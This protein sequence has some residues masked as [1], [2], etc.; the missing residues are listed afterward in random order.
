M[1]S[2]TI[3][4]LKYISK[5]EQLAENYKKEEYLIN[6]I[7]SYIDKIN[8]LIL[9]NSYNNDD[10]LSYLNIINVYLNKK[11]EHNEYNLSIIDQFTEKINKFCKKS[12]E[13]SLEKSRKYYRNKNS[14]SSNSYYISYEEVANQNCSQGYGM[15]RANYCCSPNIGLDN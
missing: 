9:N 13:D 6:F 4:H 5:K 15:S 3:T 2:N 8:K 11:C 14:S 1:K 10:F 7:N 12:I